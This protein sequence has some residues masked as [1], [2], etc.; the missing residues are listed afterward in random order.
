[1]S[2]SQNYKGGY[3]CT[4][5]DDIHITSNGSLN[6]RKCVCDRHLDTPAES[7]GDTHRLCA[8]RK[9]IGVSTPTIL[10]FLKLFKVLA[11]SKSRQ[12]HFPLKVYFFISIN[13][14]YVCLGVHCPL[15][16]FSLIW[17]RHHYRW[18]SLNFDLYSALISIEL[19]GSLAC[20]TSRDT[21]HPFITPRNR[22]THTCCRAFGSGAVTTCTCTWFLRLRSADAKI[23]TLDLLKARRTL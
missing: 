22:N 9:Y 3:Q 19:R 23:Q 21:G 15:E 16:N 10:W 7:S 20:H 18:R 6:T 5:R 8:C 14:C 17:R 2:L 13:F 12:E 4:I 11:S 1:M